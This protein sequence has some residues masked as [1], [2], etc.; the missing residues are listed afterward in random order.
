LLKR[1]WGLG[2]EELKKNESSFFGGKVK[3]PELAEKLKK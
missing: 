3:K 1:G 2:I